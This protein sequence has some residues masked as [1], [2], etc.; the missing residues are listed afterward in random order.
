MMMMVMPVMPL[1]TLFFLAQLL[2]LHLVARLAGATCLE[3]FNEEAAGQKTVEPLAALPAATHPDTG[4]S[5]EQGNR[6]AA[7]ISF[8]DFVLAEPQRTHAPGEFFLFRR[9]DREPQHGWGP[10]TP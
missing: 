4:G 2:G 10:A 3:L 7:E 8:V 6:V 5:V 1:A 9:G